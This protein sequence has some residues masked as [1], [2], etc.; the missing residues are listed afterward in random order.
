MKR[1]AAVV[2]ILFGCK[3]AICQNTDTTARL[4]IGANVNEA[5]LSGGQKA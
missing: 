4:V 1:L 2:V 3:V 5:G